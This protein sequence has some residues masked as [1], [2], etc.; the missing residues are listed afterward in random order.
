MMS[1]FI[2]LHERPSE[3]KVTF[4]LKLMGLYYTLIAWKPR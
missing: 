4:V 3:T 2:S 1:E